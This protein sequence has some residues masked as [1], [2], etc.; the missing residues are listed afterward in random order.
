VA[1]IDDALNVPDQV[2][3]V[4]VVGFSAEFKK[5]RGQGIEHAALGIGSVA[6]HCFRSQLYQRLIG[7][8][9][10]IPN[11]VHP[12]AAVEPSVIM[13]QGNQIFAGAIV[14]SAVRLGDNTIVNSGAVI[15]HDCVIGSHTHISPGAILAGGVTVGENTLVGMGVTA[16][17]GIR[18]GN[19]AVVSNG[20]HLLKDVP[21]NAVVRSS[22]R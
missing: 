2:F 1:A 10:K 17:L 14:G 20:V 18:V 22:A 8:G 11:L 15:S 4:P 5:L 21:D 19:N 9:F 6:N 16:Y 12:R 13:G 3:G 7:N